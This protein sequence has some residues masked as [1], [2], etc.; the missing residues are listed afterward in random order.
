VK[1]LRKFLVTAHVFC[2]VFVLDNFV[3]ENFGLSASVFL[4]PVELVPDSTE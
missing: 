3:F 1:E 4:T 2:S